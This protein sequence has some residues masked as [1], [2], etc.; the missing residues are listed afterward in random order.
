MKKIQDEDLILDVD[1]IDTVDRVDLKLLCTMA[2][3]RKE[4]LETGTRFGRTL[5]N[6]AKFN[7]P[8]GRLVSIDKDQSNAKQTLEKMPEEIKNK[9]TL[10]EHDT[11]TFDFSTIG[12]FDMVFIDGD[13]TSD[14]VINDTLNA[15][16]V[17]KSGGVIVWHDFQSVPIKVGL[18]TLGLAKVQI[19]KE[20]GLTYGNLDPN[21]TARV[22]KDS[23]NNI[24][25]WINNYLRIVD[26]PK[27]IQ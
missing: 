8:D 14:G 21:C 5:V 7:P 26:T 18:Y 25:K 13:H 19:G 9:I 6:L 24:Q 23:L 12:K 3:A 22:I 1:T 11:N 20:M 27:I 2:T 10:I 4:I 17:L 15:L 16:S